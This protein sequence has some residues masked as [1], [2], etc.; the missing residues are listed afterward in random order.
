ML[1]TTSSC[2]HMDK[3]TD[4]DVMPNTKLSKW[5]KAVPQDRQDEVPCVGFSSNTRTRKNSPSIVMG[6][7]T[8]SN[9]KSNDSDKYKKPDL[10]KRKHTRE[11]ERSRKENN[12]RFHTM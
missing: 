5:Y 1:L 4:Y 11:V 6:I 10:E 9:K 12:D 8:K 7:Y 3:Y 2:I